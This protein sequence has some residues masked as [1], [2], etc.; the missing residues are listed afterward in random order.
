MIFLFQPY[1]NIDY[2]FNIEFER[3]IIRNVS[4]NNNV[5]QTFSGRVLPPPQ[6]VERINHLSRK[7]GATIIVEYKHYC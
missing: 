5:V 3:N 6:G 1:Q 2:K 4:Y 7:Q